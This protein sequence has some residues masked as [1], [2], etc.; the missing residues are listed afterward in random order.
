MKH[1]LICLYSAAP[2]QQF[3]IVMQKSEFICIFTT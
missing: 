3:K 1:Q 2:N